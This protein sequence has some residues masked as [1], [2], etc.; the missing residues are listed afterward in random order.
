MRA[1]ATVVLVAAWVVTLAAGCDDKAK[2]PFPKP[3]LA[4]LKKADLKPSGFKAL[5]KPKTYG[6]KRCQVGTV[7]ELAVLICEYE[8]KEALAKSQKRRYRFLKGAVTG[9]Q[10]ADGKIA[11]VVADRDKKDLRGKTVQRILQA[12][13]KTEPF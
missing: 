7:N 6:A 9:A 13:K 12:F 1:C 5:D 3:V 8:S 2:G 11:M 4:R 10:R